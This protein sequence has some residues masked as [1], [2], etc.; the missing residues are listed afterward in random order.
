MR[1]WGRAQS[2]SPKSTR[3]VVWLQ[4]ASQQAP[5]G[6][7]Y[8]HG[9]CRGQRR[10]GG[11]DRTGLP[12]GGGENIPDEQRFL[13]NCEH[14]LLEAEF[15]NRK[16]GWHHTQPSGRPAKGP[17]KH[18][19]YHPL[20]TDR[21]EASGSYRCWLPALAGRRPSG[22]YLPSSGSG[23]RNGNFPAPLLPSWHT[24]PA[25]GSQGCLPGWPWLV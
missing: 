25:P 16:R 14:R 4:E 17:T 2:R 20:M 22:H 8:T 21:G 9:G 12:A 23:S 10:V 13:N 1:P 19:P 18:L 15:T 7:E 11:V 3:W 24:Q 5:R 6:G